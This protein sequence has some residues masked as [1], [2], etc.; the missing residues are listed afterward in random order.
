[1]TGTEIIRQGA[2]I[3]RAAGFVVRV[4]NAN[5]RTRTRNW[6]DVWACRDGVSWLIEVKGQGDRLAPG[7]REFYRQLSPH[8]GDGVRYVLAQSVE[9]FEDIVTASRYP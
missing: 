7:Q 6:I 3:L 9:D 1:M 4:F 2:A 8:L 5:R